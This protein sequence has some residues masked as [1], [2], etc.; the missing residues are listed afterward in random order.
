MT[1]EPILPLGR[2]TGRR[3]FLRALGRVAAAPLLLQPGLLGRSGRAAP[4]ARIG[5]GLIGTGNQGTVHAQV[6]L[7]LPDVEV[8]AVCDPVQGKREAAQRLVDATYAQ[9]RPGGRSTGCGAYAD[10]RELLARPDVD[11]VFIASPEHWHA[12]HTVAAARAGKDIYCEKAMASSIAESRAMVDAVR[13]YG[14]VFQVGT[15][16]RSTRQFRFACELVRNGY[17][18]R[19]HTIKVGDPSG[20][21]GPKVRNEPVPAGLDYDLWLG[22]APWKPYFPERLE[23]LKGWMLT[24]DYTVGFLSGWGQHNLDIAQWGNGTDHTGPREIEGQGTIPDDGLNDT[25]VAWHVECAYANG[26]RLVYTNDTENPYGIRFEGDAGWVFVNRS[27]LEAQPAS[28]LRVRLRGNDQP[29]YAS[30]HHHQDFLEAVRTRR[31]PVCPVEVGHRTYTICNL[32]D[33]AIRLGRKL[34]WDPERQQFPGDDPANRLL[35]RA[36]RAPWRI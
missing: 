11:A 27:G 28:L 12:L 5:V 18:G 10:F 24:Y 19:L 3:N 16:Q 26:V 17:L 15:Q 6:L 20:Y 29:L 21:P 31:D 25:A 35:A 7:G 33:I 14:R 4:S 32:C 36:M 23:N 2:P 13:R 34:R 30:P 8:V 1:S 22:P 9:R